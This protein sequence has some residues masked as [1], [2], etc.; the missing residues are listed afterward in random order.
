MKNTFTL[1]TFLFLLLINLQNTV[2]AKDL[3]G[4]EYRTKEDFLYGRFEVRMKAAHR[5]GMLS[6]FFTYWTGGEGIWNEIDI[7]IMGRYNDNV[8]FNTITPYQSYNHIGHYPM[9]TSPNHEYHT[10]AIEW[11]PFYVTWFVD[12]TEALRQLG[13]FIQTL[14]K[15][16]K[17]MMNIWQPQYENWAGVFD[18]LTLPAFAYYDWVSYYAYTP[19]SGNYGTGNNFTHVWTDDFNSWDTTR[20]DKATHTF[21]GNNSD[22]IQENAVFK[23]GNLILCLTNSTNIGYTDVAPP[24]LLYAR[25]S[26]G[27]V[28]AV[29]SEEV[30][31]TMAEDVTRY[32]I[33]GVTINSAKLLSDLKSVELSVT[34]LTIPSTNNL[35]VL[36]MKDR[37]TPPNTA[38]A[39]LK[40]IIMPAMLSFPIKINCGGPAELGYLPDTAFSRNTDYGYL[41]GTGTVYPSSLSISGTDEDA[42]FR[43]DRYSLVGYKIRVP[44]GNYDVKLLFAEKYFTSA[45][46]RK[47]NVYIELS[48]VIFDLDIFGQV[49]SNTA[50][51][52]EVK[53]V[54]VNDGILDIHL[55]DNIDNALISGI[56]ITP[57]TTGLYEDEGAIIR[58]FK[59][60][61]NFPNPFNGKTTIKYFLK[62]P[63]DVSFHLYN[64][65]GEQIFHKSLGYKSEGEHKYI[66]DSAEV[67]KV[68]LSSGVYFYTLSVSQKK[69]THKLVLLN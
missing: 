60:D 22:F 27:K 33:N 65:L 36:S 35:I 6:S 48:K 11:T 14:T 29:F 32:F 8:Q 44:N 43:S 53:N 23:D 55:S 25:A 34:G 5:E 51:I 66:F 50:N 26:E 57:N 37:W 1:T 42:I 45:N 16:Q 12:G 20:W 15:P 63:D 28:T 56:V 40:P 9:S 61:Q 64:I 39:I 52:K 69:E 24:S 19:G 7:E 68:T 46:S 59:V 54:S 10:Y 30:D 58:E 38:G 4:A 3:K 47:F 13:D 67:K 18:P 41:D 17:I 21:G 49:G 31:Q 2:N 62:S